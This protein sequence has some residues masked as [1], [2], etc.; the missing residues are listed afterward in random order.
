MSFDTQL[1]RNAYLQRD[2]SNIDMPFGKFAASYLGV[3]DKVLEREENVSKACNMIIN[4][5]YNVYKVYHG[6][7]PHNSDGA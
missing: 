2:V 4:K 1:I 5:G 7:T 3:K 6:Q